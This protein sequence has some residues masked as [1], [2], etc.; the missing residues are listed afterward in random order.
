MTEA[1]EYIALHDISEIIET[2]IQ[3]VVDKMS[4]TPMLTLS[5][6]FTLKHENKTLG[7]ENIGYTEATYKAYIV[8]HNF[9][10]V[11]ASAICHVLRERSPTPMLTLSR[12]FA[13]K[14]MDL[15]RRIWKRVA[16]RAIIIRRFYA[17]LLV[18]YALC[19]RIE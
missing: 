15:H 16:R 13:V 2:A 18:L 4:P 10:E 9:Q 17:Y 19:R 12:F 6:Y 7:T 5:R 14:Q 1:F 3:H 8:S 11:F